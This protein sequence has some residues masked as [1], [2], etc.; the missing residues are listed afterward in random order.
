M[1]EE[2]KD[3]SGSG[4]SNISAS[5]ENSGQNQPGYNINA[6][7]GLAAGEAPP[8]DSQKAPLLQKL[9]GGAPSGKNQ[10]NGNVFTKLFGNST[11][12]GSASSVLPN[13]KNMPV[14]GGE[15]K[16][17]QPSISVLLGPKPHFENRSAEQTE[18]KRAKTGRVFLY[19]VCF[20]AVAVFGFFYSQLNPDFT[21]LSDYLG[22]PN[23]A[24]RFENTNAEIETKQTATNNLRYRMANLWL[25]EASFKIDSFQTAMNILDSASVSTLAKQNAENQLVDLETKIKDALRNFQNILKAPLGIETFSLSPV[26]PEQIETQYLELL[27][28]SLNRERA[29]ATNEGKPN[30]DALRLI[31]NVLRLVENKSFWDSVRKEDLGKMDRNEL[32]GLLAKIRN[33]GTDELSAIYKI[34]SKRLDWGSVIRDIHAAITRQADP[35]YG[36]GLFQTVGGFLFSSYRFDSKTNRIS[37]SGITKSAETKVFSAIS[38]LIESIERSRS[39]KDIDFRSFAKSR[40]ENGDFTSSLNL[41]FS[42][43]EGEDTRDREQKIET[44]TPL[45]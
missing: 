29:L 2:I 15:P 37:I 22:G 34:R 5:S 35:Y 25:A 30:Q 11:V 23:V 26:S 32:A 33:A 19:A 27:K 16:K 21:L 6:S 10:S 43:Q 18:A 7:K 38:D 9:L 31:D 13:G 28:E 40:D 12:S 14:I 45:P 24:A 3:L 1:T 41:E 4:V 44:N 8:E 39:F 36:Q 17:A 42:L 20:I